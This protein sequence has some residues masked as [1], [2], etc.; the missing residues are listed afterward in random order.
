MTA[1]PAISLW[2]PYPSLVACGAK[3]WETR[4]Y[5]PPKHLIGHR[6]ALHAA[7]RRPTR[8]EFAVLNEAASEAFG[9]CHW[10][11]THPL[12][13]LCLHSDTGSR[14]LRAGPFW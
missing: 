10:H 5:P 4:G 2:Q 11:P 14:A 13:G 3:P 9:F 8:A 7:K 1:L 6:I 12:R